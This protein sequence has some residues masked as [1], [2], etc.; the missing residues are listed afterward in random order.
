MTKWMKNLF[1]NDKV[2]FFLSFFVAVVLWMLVVSD[3]NPQIDSVLRSV[4]ISYINTESF[5][6]S[7][8]EIISSSA[9]NA[10]VKI[11]GRLSEVYRVSGKDIV[12]S[13]DFSGIYSPGTYEIP[14]TVTAHPTSVSVE[15][16][17][18]EM[19]K[20]QIDYIVK[21]KREV[22]ILYQGELPEGYELDEAKLSTTSV[23]IE[24]PEN[25]IAS[26][27]KAV[28]VIE[29]DNL[30]ESKTFECPLKL[31]SIDGSEVSYDNL[32]LSSTEVLVEQKVLMIKELPVQ[33]ILSGE[34]DLDALGVSAVVCD[35]ANV[36][37]KGEKEILDKMS[38]I[39]TE[40]IPTERVP[41]GNG[42]VTIKLNI[43]D[44]LECGV[45]NIIA[46]FK[47]N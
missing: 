41:E 12:L 13:A 24:G 30:T 3:R 8:L 38:Q 9:S 39:E 36:I 22:E 34:A 16:V 6:N 20:V 37:V 31:I 15:T 32:K 26:I 29:L 33:V 23:T 4:P 11:E 19:M 44:G 10:N 17:D 7:G 2:L 45:E 42:R 35:P 27:S 14:I 18:P 5:V 25:K 1:Q 47:L 28:A 46:V 40:P 21:N 43:P